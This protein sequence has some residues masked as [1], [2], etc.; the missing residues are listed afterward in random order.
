M[1]KRLT[2]DPRRF[3][4]VEEQARLELGMRSIYSSEWFWAKIAHLFKSMWY[5]SFGGYPPIEFLSLIHTGLPRIAATLGGKTWTSDQACGALIAEWGSRLHL[6]A[7]PP[8]AVGSYGAHMGA[9]GGGV[10]KGVLVK[11][12]STFTCDMRVGPAPKSEERL[13]LG[14][15]IKRTVYPRPAFHSKYATLYSRYRSLGSCAEKEF[16]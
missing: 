13:V 16:S 2:I 1:P 6:T 12:I 9:V 5:N 7:L 3:A 10:R 11:V 15:L 8:M 4:R 14:M